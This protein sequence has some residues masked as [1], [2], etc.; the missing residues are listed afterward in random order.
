M[1]QPA[2]C[3][4]TVLTV[5]K[6]PAL[7]VGSEGYKQHDVRRSAQVLNYYATGLQRKRRSVMLKNVSDEAVLDKLDEWKIKKTALFEQLECLQFHSKPLPEEPPQRNYLVPKKR[8]MLNIGRCRKR[9]E[10]RRVEKEG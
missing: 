10:R 8:R 6:G 3:A 2:L 1:I 7:V 4:H 9:V 5:G